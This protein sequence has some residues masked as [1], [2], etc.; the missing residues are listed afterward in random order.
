MNNAV[1]RKT[2]ENIRNHLDIKLVS[3]ERRRN[4]LVSQPNFHT[5]KL[6]RKSINKRNE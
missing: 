2:M 1:F 5:K 3:T 4:D 6:F